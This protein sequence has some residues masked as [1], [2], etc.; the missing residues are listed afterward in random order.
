M[1]KF[2]IVFTFLMALCISAL[3]AQPISVTVKVVFSDG[4]PVSGVTMSAFK[5]NTGG[6][7]FPGT[8]DANGLIT[9]ALPWTGNGIGLTAR[10]KYTNAFTTVNVGTTNPVPIHSFSTTVAMIEVKDCN[11]AAV[12]NCVV[13]YFNPNNGGGTVGTTGPTGIVST[14]LFPGTYNFSARINHTQGNYNVDITSGSPIDHTFVPT[15][16]QFYNPLGAVKCW[17][18]NSGGINF[19]GPTYMF[20]GTY[21][22]D[23]Y[24]GQ[25]TK[26]YT[27]PITLN[28]GD[29]RFSGGA[30]RLVDEAGTPL[31]NYPADYPAETRNLKWKYR[32]GGS[33]GPSTSFQT[34]ANGYAFFNISCANNNWDKKITMTLNQTSREQDVTVNSTFQAARVNV[35]LEACSPTTPLSGGVV[36]QGGGYWYTHGNT[37]ANG[38]RTFYTFPASSIKVRMSY[39][40]NNETQ[41]PAIAAG[42]ND[43]YFNTT[44]LTLNYS[45]DIKSNMGGSWWLFSK[46]TM[47]LLAGNYNFWFKTGSIWYGPVAINVTGCNMSGVLLRVLDENGNGVA[48][49]KAT[50]AYGGGWGATLPGQT[51]ANGALFANITPGFTK[52]KMD[53]NQGGQEQTVAQLNASNYTWYTEILRIWLKDHNG[54]A[55]TDGA[56]ILDQGGGYWYG[57][58]NFNTSGYRDIQ[59]FPRPGSYKFKATYNYTSEEKL[60]VVT[61]GAGI[62]NFDFQTGQVFGSCITQYSTGSWQTFTD[63]MELMPGTYT[64]KSPTQS[65]TIT[66]GGITYLTG[67]PTS[68][69]Y[70]GNP[71]TPVADFVV[72][73]NPFSKQATIRYT[74]KTDDAVTVSIFDARGLEVTKLYQGFRTAGDYSEVWEGAAVPPGVYYLRILTSEGV[75]THTII[76]E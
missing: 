9:G 1:K 39:N 31:A 59:L 76:K 48:G 62:Q 33:W 42:V 15:I 66:A 27:V 57:W 45:S 19:T 71:D 60:P 41:Y 4:S 35:H 14:E 17:V 75:T 32:C 44:R 70:A 30:M 54:N 68:A 55:F 46:P 67:C 7:T 72:F 11:N 34:D 10:Y 6:Y 65:G 63:G 20:P 36:A 69:G 40:H 21:A 61:A 5:P 22:I 43:V 3:Q 26:I 13:T 23:F 50:P 24:Q 51:D 64:F 58:G 18:P 12:Q 28:S 38:V 37:D 8:T 53:V 49:G 16:V 52:I 25:N 74:M 29:C 47:D 56:G 73:P 2:S